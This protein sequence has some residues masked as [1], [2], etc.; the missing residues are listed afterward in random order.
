MVYITY[1]LVPNDSG[2]SS[3]GLLTQLCERYL[4]GTTSSLTEGVRAGDSPDKTNIVIHVTAVGLCYHVGLIE[5]K[6]NLI[7]DIYMSHNLY[8]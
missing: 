1:L 6:D 2:S 7:T 4:R 5:L 3:V 8:V